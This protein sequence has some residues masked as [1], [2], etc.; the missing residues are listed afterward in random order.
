MVPEVIFICFGIATEHPRVFFG[1][2]SKVIVQ[3]GS[4][5]VRTVYNEGFSIRNGEVFTFQRDFGRRWPQVAAIKVNAKVVA[6]FTLALWRR[7]IL[8]GTIPSRVAKEPYT[9]FR[10]VATSN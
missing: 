4:F 3:A 2:W 6:D 5:V 8:A 9:R 7:G 1:R 10:C